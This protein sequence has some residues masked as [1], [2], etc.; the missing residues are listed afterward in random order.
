LDKVT[1]AYRGATYEIGLGRDCFGIWTV[2]GSRPVFNKV[3]R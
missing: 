1:I 3:F 2:D